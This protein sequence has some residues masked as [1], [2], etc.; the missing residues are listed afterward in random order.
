MNLGWR[1]QCPIPILFGIVPLYY[2][3][4]MFDPSFLFLIFRLWIVVVRQ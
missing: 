1:F 4:L 3:L 2:L